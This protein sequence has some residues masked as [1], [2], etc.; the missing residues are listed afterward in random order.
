MLVTPRG[1]LYV[2]TMF[3]V[4]LAKNRH[5]IDIEYN[6]RP[7]SVESAEVSYDGKRRILI[8]KTFD[9]ELLKDATCCESHRFEQIMQAFG[10]ADKMAALRPTCSLVQLNATACNGCPDRPI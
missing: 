8:L 1:S 4:R 7:I 9:F 10:N 2:S 6:G 3:K 5:E